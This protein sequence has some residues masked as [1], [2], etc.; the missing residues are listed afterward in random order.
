MPEELNLRKRVR[1][2]IV[3]LRENTENAP[4]FQR[5][6]KTLAGVCVFGG[7]IPALGSGLGLGVAGSGRGLL[8]WGD[9]PAAWAC[10]EE[11][12]E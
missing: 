7:D 11:K 4:R 8:R 9:V 5:S 12:F 1:W 2:G 6:G 3:E 10:T